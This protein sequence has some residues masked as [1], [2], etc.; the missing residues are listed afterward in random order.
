M[1]DYNRDGV[2]DDRDEQDYWDDVY[3]EEDMEDLNN[4]YTNYGGN[5]TVYSH[6]SSHKEKKT[7]KFWPGGFL[8][9]VVIVLVAIV[10]LAIGLPLLVACPP[11]GLMVL[12]PIWIPLSKRL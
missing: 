5:R 3:Y 6:T 8:F 2:I 9:S 10:L 1:W 11:L 7:E 4:K 12:A